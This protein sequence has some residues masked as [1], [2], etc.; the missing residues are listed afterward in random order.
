MIHIDLGSSEPL[1]DQ[2]HREIQTAVARGL[3]RRGDALPSVRQLAGD[4]GVH[5]NTVARAYRRLRD[6]GLLSVGRGRP[7]VVRSIELAGAQGNGKAN[8][9]GMLDDAITQAK[10]H[11]FT[12]EELQAAV[13]SRLNAWRS[14]WKEDVI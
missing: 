6:D 9:D 1:E 10:L 12:F 7:V 4:L 8:V 14:A 13:Q 11:G 3:V 5:W 2:I